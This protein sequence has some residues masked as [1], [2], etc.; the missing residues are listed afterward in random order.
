MSSKDFSPYHIVNL[1]TR[2]GL[3]F[4]YREQTSDIK[5]IREACGNIDLPGEKKRSSS[6]ERSY[7][8]PIFKCEPD[9][10]WLD[11]GAQI[12]SF[13]LRALKN[14][15]K[16]VVAV[17]PEDDNHDLLL[18]NIGL[19]LYEPYVTV[20][21]CVVVAEDD[22][23]VGDTYLN[24]T[25]ST[26]RH[27]LLPIKKTTSAQK[28]NCTTLNEILGKHDDITAVKIDIEGSEYKVVRSVNWKD[29]KIKKLVFEYSFDHHPVM[30][31]F[32]DLIDDLRNQF[33]V[34]YHIASLPPRGETW[35]TKVTRGANG[36]LVWCLK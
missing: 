36:H 14:G 30:D 12:G 11:C 18:R 22:I 21:K 10:V 4:T 31:K 7:R 1:Q 25:T 5:A 26:Y 3:K 13:T 19:N 15:V 33:R 2:D 28:V 34:V 20:L 29:T 16:K 32:Y 6:Y 27:T 8:S 24:K 23:N 9:D 17:E 35:N